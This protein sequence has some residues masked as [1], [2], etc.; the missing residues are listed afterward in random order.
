MKISIDQMSKLSHYKGL[1]NSHT[2][3][4]NQEGKTARSKYFFQTGIKLEASTTKTLNLTRAT[5]SWFI[6]QQIS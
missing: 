4:S 6:D 2:K 5:L 1:F 3:R